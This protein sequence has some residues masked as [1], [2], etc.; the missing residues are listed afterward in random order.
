MI[1]IQSVL[2]DLWPPHPLPPTW[3]KTKKR[4]SFDVSIF[5]FLVSFFLCFF[6]VFAY[7]EVFSCSFFLQMKWLQALQ[8]QSPPPPSQ[9]ENFFLDYMIIWDRTK[10]SSI[11][12]SWVY[13]GGGW[14]HFTFLLIS[15]I[16]PPHRI[17]IVHCI[18]YMGI[19]NNSDGLITCR[20]VLYEKPM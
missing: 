16:W 7:W 6:V 17:N 9:E 15:C 13:S 14:F 3:L 18:D 1:K 2:V 19:K 8:T 5:F 11:P 10:S 20:V 4:I 12:S